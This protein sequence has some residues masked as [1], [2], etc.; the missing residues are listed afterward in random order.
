MRELAFKFRH[1]R[2][3]HRLHLVV[4]K[5]L[6]GAAV[7]G[8]LAV[9]QVRSRIPYVAHVVDA[10]LVGSS[11]LGEE[12][13]AFVGRL[14]DL[15]EAYAC[16]FQYPLD[17]FFTFVAHLDH[18]TRILGKQKFHEVVFLHLVETDFHTAFHV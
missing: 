3:L 13:V 6:L 8:L 12:D 16:V 5:A 9:E 4:F 17:L 7:H 18:D 15:H 2:K 11:V 10:E 1:E 14:T